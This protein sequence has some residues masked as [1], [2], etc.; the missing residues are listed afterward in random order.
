[1]A[2]EVRNLCEKDWNI[3][4]DEGEVRNLCEKQPKM[5]ADL[6]TT[7]LPQLLVMRAFLCMSRS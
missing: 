2:L 5:I 6:L 7:V 3:E 1:M 4:S